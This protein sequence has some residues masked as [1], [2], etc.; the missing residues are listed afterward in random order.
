MRSPATQAAQPHVGH[1]QEK[2]AGEAAFA[3]RRAPTRGWCR[4]FVQLGALDSLRAR[5][6]RRRARRGWARPS[7]CSGYGGV[8]VGRPFLTTVW[9]PSS[10]GTFNRSHACPVRLCFDLE[11]PVRFRFTTGT[12]LPPHRRLLYFRFTTTGG[13]RTRK[14]KPASGTTLNETDRIVCERHQLDMATDRE[15]RLALRLGCSQVAINHQPVAVGGSQCGSSQ[16]ACSHHPRGGATLAC[17]CGRC[18]SS[19]PSV[20]PHSLCRPPTHG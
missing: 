1:A 14:S 5:G 18:A 3:T 17:S 13:T 7:R 10:S 6:V 15:G 20:D 2:G 4:L 8:H 16:V 11:T 19:T 9:K 12:T